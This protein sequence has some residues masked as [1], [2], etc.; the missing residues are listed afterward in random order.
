MMVPLLLPR[1]I[2]VALLAAVL[3]ML[4]AAPAYSKRC[5]H[6]ISPPGNSGVGQ[7]SENVPTAC[8]NQSTSTVPPSGSGHGP[9]AGT[10]S[11]SGSN[12]SGG[13]GG[14][15]VRSISAGTVHALA[16][17]GP[18]GA[19]AANFAQ[20]TA[21]TIAHHTPGRSRTAGRTKPNNQSTRLGHGVPSPTSSVFAALTGSS[22]SGGLGLLL[23]ILLGVTFVVMGGSAL[24]RSHRTTN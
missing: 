20:A 4:T 9:G 6:R 2:R 8:G 13:A 22:G 18:A 5:S 11:S 10:G 21:P 17:Q 7:Y 12:S 1:D 24:L 15:G 14:S 16:A 23:P 3:L 19:A